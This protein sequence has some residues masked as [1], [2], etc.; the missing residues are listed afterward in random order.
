M[1]KQEVKISIDNR[2]IVRIM[3]VAVGFW[4]GLQVIGIL[5]PILTLIIIS[6]FFAMALNQPVSY[7]T[8]KMTQGRRT[9]ATAISYIFVVSIIGLF[10]AIVVPPFAR[11]SAEFIDN[12][13]ELAQEIRD[14]EGVIGEWV[15]NLNLE[16]EVDELTNN[17]TDILS[18]ANDRILSGITAVG[19]FVFS[20]LTVLVLTFFML[21]EGPD[22]INHYWEAQKPEFRKH[23]RPL[24]NR[25]YKVVTAYVNGQLLIALIAALTS[26][27]AMLIVQIPYPLPLA[28]V[29]GLFGL[30][31]LV[32][33]TLGSV[34]VIVFA[35]F[36]SVYAAVF[37]LIF[38]LVY[39]QIENNAIQPYIQ[40]KNL[41]VSP[42]IVLVAV[43]F[44]AVLGGLVGGLIAIPVAACGRILYE[45]YHD[46]RVEIHSEP[47]PTKK[48]K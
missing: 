4:I 24:V 44:G 36:K 1:A 31:P 48:K 46:R 27:V 37:M 33:A 41:N 28:T 42:L 35:L 22:W 20:L 12:L 29:V 43:L 15:T 14:G 19:T 6:L 32:G 9:L 7:L 17:L 47:E 23:Y 25:M 34:V 16:E 30:I 2:T 26:L 5:A 39:Q 40:S 18:S 8:N 38:F 21:V 13:P 10:I 45:D 11:E 3:A